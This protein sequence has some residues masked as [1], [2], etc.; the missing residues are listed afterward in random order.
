MEDRAMKKRHSGIIPTFLVV[1]AI[2]CG[3]AHAEGDPAEGRNEVTFR[4]W[5]SSLGVRF[6]SESLFE[7]TVLAPFPGARTAA[8]ELSG[9]ASAAGLQGFSLGG[10][11]RPFGNGFRLNFAM[12]LDPVEPGTPG[13]FRSRKLAEIGSASDDLVSLSD[14]EA[15]SYVGLG[16][17][18]N[19]EGLGVNL[20]VGAF[21]SEDYSPRGEFCPGS[22][23]PLSGCGTASFG[24][25][26]SGSFRK[27]E[28]YPVV[29]LGIEYRF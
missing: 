28:W 2:S 21:L 23:S 26:V 6:H 12:Y 14:F 11:W 4:P 16:W 22:D 24:N 27:F 8:S 1:T 20:D 3:A 5:I 10:E 15:V 13:I 29:S 7:E 17:R 18:A 9:Q 25:K 19:G